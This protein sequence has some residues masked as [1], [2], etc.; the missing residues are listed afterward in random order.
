LAQT[1]QEFF[2]QAVVA[3][4]HDGA[5]GVEVRAGPRCP[6]SRPRSLRTRRTRASRACDPP[7]R[8]CGARSS[9]ELYSL[10]GQV[11]G[12]RPRPTAPARGAIPRLPVWA[13]PRSRTTP[14]K[15][16]ATID[17]ARCLLEPDQDVDEDGE[18]DRNEKRDQQATG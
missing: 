12:S 7:E 11:A 4:R 18:S 6:R 8:S 17:T 9:S 16:A 13:T 10:D 14:A 1:T 15:R 5:L 2:D 3:E